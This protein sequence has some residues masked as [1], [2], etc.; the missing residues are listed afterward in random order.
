M[1][2]IFSFIIH[3]NCYFVGSE[4]LGLDILQKPQTISIPKIVSHQQYMYRC[5]QL[6]ILNKCIDDK[7]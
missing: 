3:K 7:F 4:I 1:V 6:C 2:T 5:I